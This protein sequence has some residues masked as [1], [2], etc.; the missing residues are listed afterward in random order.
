M[1]LSAL[2]ARPATHPQPK[3]FGVDLLVVAFKVT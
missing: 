1:V 3:T 2:V